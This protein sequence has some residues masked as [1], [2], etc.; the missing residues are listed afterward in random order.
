MKKNNNE[1]SISFKGLDLKDE[2]AKRIEKA[3]PKA[4]INEIA[5]MDLTREH[6][7]KMIS[8]RIIFGM[9]FDWKRIIKL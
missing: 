1:F 7:Y 8:P 2:Q 6:S 9:I 3:I 5:A 4:A